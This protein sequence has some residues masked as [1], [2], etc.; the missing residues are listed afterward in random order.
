MR[1]LLLKDFY[2]MGKNIVPALITAVCVG[3]LF[4]VQG[5]PMMFVLGITLAGGTVC[6]ACLRMDETAGW[7][8]YELIVPVKRSWIVFEKYLLLLLLT[9]LGTV[10]GSI[11]S[12]IA[13]ILT[14]TYEIAKLLMYASVGFSLGMISGSLIIFCVLKFGGAKADFFM[15]ICYLLPVGIFIGILLI[16]KKTDAYMENGF[17]DLFIRYFFPGISVILT[18]ALA[19]TAVVVYKKKQF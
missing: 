1:G 16:L 5:N 9:V 15:V 19:F 8:K 10:F 2:N 13:G 14:G 12:G 17:P 3:L 6:T 7:E 11:I 4:A 18:G